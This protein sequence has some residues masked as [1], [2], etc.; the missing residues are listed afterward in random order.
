MS[1][2]LFHPKAWHIDIA[3]HEECEHNSSLPR[4][5]SLR[6]CHPQTEERQLV[7]DSIRLKVCVCVC[8]SAH[9]TRGLVETGTGGG[10]KRLFGVEV[11]E[12]GHGRGEVGHNGRA[13]TGRVEE[14]RKTQSTLRLLFW[15]VLHLKWSYMCEWTSL[16]QKTGLVASHRKQ[17][18]NWDLFNMCQSLLSTK[19]QCD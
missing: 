13:L 14:L 8:V 9:Y 16:E 1:T 17:K 10:S 18:H 12:V 5:C 19:Q 4:T 7:S 15:D 6:L 3:F 2:M 11:Q